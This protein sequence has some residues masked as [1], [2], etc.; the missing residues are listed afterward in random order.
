[1]FACHSVHEHADDV[2]CLHEPGVQRHGNT[3]VDRQVGKSIKMLGMSVL[4]G[5]TFLGPMP[6]TEYKYI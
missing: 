5:R 3:Y 4:I 1:M 6:S 2:S